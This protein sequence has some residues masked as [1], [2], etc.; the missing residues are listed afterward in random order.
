MGTQLPQN[1]LQKCRKELHCMK[2]SMQISTT[3][4][5]ELRIGKDEDYVTIKFLN[6]INQIEPN[7]AVFTKNT[8]LNGSKQ[9]SINDPGINTLKTFQLRRR[10]S[11]ARKTSQDKSQQGELQNIKKLEG[12]TLWGH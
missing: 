2:I 7:A 3:F 10:E 11:I 12:G 5:R 8:K 9:D 4:L 1:Y 6:T